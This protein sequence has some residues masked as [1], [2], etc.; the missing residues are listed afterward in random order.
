[1]NSGQACRIVASFSL[2][3]LL[4]YLTLS[5]TSQYFDKES[6]SYDTETSNAS[7]AASLRHV[8]NVLER[9]VKDCI[10]SPMGKSSLT[11]GYSYLLVLY[12]FEQMN[13]ALKNL[14]H[15]G[16]IAMNL[17][18]KIVEPFVVHSRLYGLPD[19]LPAGEVTGS[20]YSLRTLFN[21]DS[22]NQSLNAYANA[23][24]ASFH[25]FILYAPRDV[26][27]V[28]FIHKE[29]PRPR[30]FRLSYHYLR[31]L[32]LVSESET[33]AIDCTNE[34]FYEEQIYGGLLG[35][36][37]NITVKYGAVNFR[38]A[39]FICV[40]GE[41]DVTTNQLRQLFNPEKKTVIIPEWR[42]CGYKHCNLEMRHYFITHARPKLLYTLKGEKQSPL[43]F[44]YEYSDLV[45]ETASL[46]IKNLNL[47]KKPYISVYMR[48]EKLLKTNNTFRIDKNYLKCCTSTLQ[49]VLTSVKKR[50]KLSD[51][52]LITDLGR[53]GSDAC[54][55]DCQR[56]GE[57][58]L[59]DVE[60]TNKIKVF[61][62]NPGKTPLKID[63]G[64]FAAMVEMEMLARARRL[65]TVGLG[66]FK[67]QL[68]QSYERRNT[69]TNVYSVCKEM[70]LN[71][72]HDFGSLPSH[73]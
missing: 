71:V 54:P 48:I 18:L 17:D 49:R 7:N 26:V 3:Y 23:S 66:Q 60:K 1:M 51:V 11:N 27:V 19:M 32:K 47:T 62:Y 70:R 9:N 31:I 16:P 46:L 22:I 33:P 12:Y 52:L 53:Y 15:L 37:L 42:G 69:N 57:Q 25:D 28:Y 41:R 29:H 10:E 39:K 45:M 20:F 44:S 43:N 35:T 6:I 63:N 67:E 50:F 24:L 68:I 8:H 65:I 36:L 59:K 40:A 58:I 34:I 61:D 14:L 55:G 2:G 30:T 64:G 5:L 56:V 38:I 21:I 73:C 72:L 13:N 4:G